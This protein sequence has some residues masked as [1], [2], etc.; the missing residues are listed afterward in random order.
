MIPLRWEELCLGGWYRYYTIVLF[1]F[2]DDKI[3][4]KLL[5]T[6]IKQEQWVQINE[7]ILNNI[8]EKIAIL[9]LEGG[10][11]YTSEFLKQFTRE[12]G[13]QGSLTMLFSEIKGLTYH[14]EADPIDILSTRV[15]FVILLPV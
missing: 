8:P 11:K 10:V 15:S 12:Y 7:F 4:L 1:Y 6:S 2:F 3:S 14:H 5:L 13:L 9:D